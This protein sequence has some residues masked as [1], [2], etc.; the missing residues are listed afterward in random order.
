MPPALC[1]FLNASFIFISPCQLFHHPPLIRG[2]KGERNYCGV[3]RVGWD[4]AVI[5]KKN[6]Y[7]CICGKCTQGVLG[8]YITGG[9]GMLISHCVFF[10]FS[11]V[12]KLIFYRYLLLVVLQFSTCAVLIIELITWLFFYPG[13]GCCS[14][15][16]LKWNTDL[17]FLAGC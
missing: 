7:I 3:A 12:N 10:F 14:L 8:G 1:S 16:S 9:R 13:S 5:V 11:S 4:A 15:H 17:D 6:V 2:W